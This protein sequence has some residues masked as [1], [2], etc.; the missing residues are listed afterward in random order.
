MHYLEH[1][2]REDRIYPSNLTLAQKKATQGPRIALAVDGL[3][4]SGKSSIA[5]LVAR[6]IGARILDPFSGPIGTVLVHLARNGRQALADDLAHAA[7]AAA[8]AEVPPGPVVFDRHWF[9]ASQ[10]L[11]PAFRSGWDPR[12]YAVMCWADRRRSLG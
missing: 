4:G 2:R 6:E 5:R 12:P 1:G 9:T 8:M 11:S 7:V 10:L 3:D